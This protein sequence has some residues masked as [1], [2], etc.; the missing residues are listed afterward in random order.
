M[1]PR[2]LIFSLLLYFLSHIGAASPPLAADVAPTLDFAR[3]GD[4][5]V[6][7]MNYRIPEGY[8]AY[9]HEGA[10]TGRPTSLDFTLEGRGA[11]PVLYPAGALQRDQFDPQITVAAYKGEITL[12]VLLPEDARGRSYAAE[13]SMLLCSARHCIPVSQRLAGTVPALLPELSESAW[14]ESALAL[15]QSAHMADVSSPADS[16]GDELLFEEGRAPPLVSASSPETRASAVRQLPPDDAT[17]PPPEDFNLRLKPRYAAMDLEIFGLGKALLLG[18]L[19][20]LILN[21]MPCVLPVLTFKLSG[22]LLMGGGRE[23]RLRLFREHN[24][25]FAAGILTLFTL[26]ALL[27]GLADLMWGQLYQ[28]QGVLLVMLILVF[29]L[30]LSMLGVFSLPS[31]DLKPGASS[32]NPRLQSYLTGFFSTFLATPCSGP[33]LGGVLGWAF[34]QPLFVLVVVFW[35]VGLGMAL[36]YLVFS[37]WPALA[38]ILPRPGAWMHVFEHILG[39]LLLGTALYL[40]SMLPVEKH[41]QVLSVLLLVAFC[42]WLWGRYCSLSAPPMR[43]RVLGLAGVALLCLAVVWVLRPVYPMPQWRD[44]SPEYFTANLGKKPLLLEFTADWCPN[45]KYLEATVLT[46]E[47]LR[48][49][50]AKYHMELI[51]V[52]LTRPNAYAVRLLDMLGSKSIPVTALFPKGEGASSPLVLRDLYS[53]ADLEQALEQTFSQ[54]VAEAI[55]PGP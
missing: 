42:A 19:A 55:E 29:L 47:H 1:M 36:P 31:F 33:L 14:R 20:G 37:I 49:W 7:A 44:F 4:G 8:H 54:Q 16:S 45:C 10:D 48:N 46:N 27:L 15:L 28:N 38:R 39:F 30:G 53:T 43:R 52:D 25:C 17:L 12:L 26:L 34:T 3:Y 11:M 21:A 2:T 5:V 9:A 13:L 32:G 6:A 35:F 22:L 51:R 41:M 24:L 50:E 40:L 18:L 23:K